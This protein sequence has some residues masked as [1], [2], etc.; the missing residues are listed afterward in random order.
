MQFRQWLEENSELQKLVASLEQQYPEI[1]S[2]FA[3]E[4][5]YSVELSDIKIHKDSRNQG[6][7][8]AVISALKDFAA[9]V[10]KPLIVAPEPGKG[11]KA[12][13][14]RFYRRNGLIP[15][16]GRNKDY[17]LS[18]PFSGTMYWKPPQ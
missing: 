10:G 17:R 18:K 16:K 1:A 2:L 5:I 13:L 14:T 6:I 4:N 9:S 8:S 15:N 12:A 7:G 11:K 3:W